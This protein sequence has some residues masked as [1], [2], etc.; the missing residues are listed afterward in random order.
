MLQGKRLTMTGL[1][2]ATAGQIEAGIHLRW[3]MEAGMGFPPF[4]FSLYRRAHVPGTPVCSACS[5]PPAT[6][7]SASAPW[8]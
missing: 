5:R 4:G 7:P 6:P 3:T 2:L 8:G 1:G